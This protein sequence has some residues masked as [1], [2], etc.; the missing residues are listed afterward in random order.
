RYS[1]LFVI[2]TAGNGNPPISGGFNGQVNYD[3]GTS[4]PFMYNAFDWCGSL[5][6]PLAAIAGL[7]RA[8][9]ITDA[10]NVF[11]YNTCGGGT[12]LYETEVDVDNT[13]NVLSIDFTG[14]TGALGGYV[15]NI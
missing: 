1:Q 9:S 2:A 12:G 7:G 11:S 8:C 15:I 4:Q 6:Q 14:H 3:D 5:S 10:G 13:K